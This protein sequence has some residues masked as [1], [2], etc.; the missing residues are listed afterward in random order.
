MPKSFIYP[1]IPV[2]ILTS[3]AWA[4]GASTQHL[5]ASEFWLYVGIFLLPALAVCTCSWLVFQKV[6]WEKVVGGILL[7]PSLAVWLLSLLLV[8]NGFKI[9]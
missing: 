9:H 2:F 4:I 6:L 3:M 8:A 1:A 7:L 5:L